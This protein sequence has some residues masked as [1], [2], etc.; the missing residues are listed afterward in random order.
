MCVWRVLAP[1]T[2]LTNP[3]PRIWS[4]RKFWV[5]KTK[6]K[7]SFFLSR[8]PNFQLVSRKILKSPIFQSENLRGWK[9]KE[10]KIIYFLNFRLGSLF[11]FSSTSRP[12]QLL[13]CARQLLFCVTWPIGHVKNYSVCACIFSIKIVWWNKSKTYMYIFIDFFA[14]AAPP[15]FQMHNVDFFSFVARYAMKDK[16]IK[17]Y[18]VWLIFNFISCLIFY[19]S[20]KV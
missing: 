18:L 2:A 10:K 3:A 19:H 7:G 1:H 17:Y 11:F 13:F 12:G 20:N 16:Q 15:P 14:T 8:I 6:R 5:P 9:Q 4:F